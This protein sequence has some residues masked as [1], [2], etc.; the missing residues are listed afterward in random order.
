MAATYVYWISTGLL[1]LLYL[2]SAAL[3]VAKPA[4]VRQAQVDLGYHAAHLVPFMIAI[5][6]LGS[7]AILSRVSLPLSDLAYA[8]ILFHLLLSG[9]AHLGVHKPKGAVPA[10]IGLMA[11]AASFTTQNAARPGV[12]P[13]AP[14]ASA[15]HTI[16]QG[17]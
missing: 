12:S 15:F 1:E 16:T 14:A 9:M 4:F 8:G 11:L 13:Y 17:N 6:V 7:A 5:K 3:Y 2:S 10:A